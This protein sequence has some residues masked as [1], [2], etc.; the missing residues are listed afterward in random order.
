MTHETVEC[1]EALSTGG[2]LTKTLVGQGYWLLGIGAYPKMHRQMLGPFII[3]FA[4]KLW[5]K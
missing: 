2:P 4:P 1:M 5:S 3:A